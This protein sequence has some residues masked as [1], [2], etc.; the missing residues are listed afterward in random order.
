MKELQV[1]RGEN[2]SL[3]LQVGRVH[4]AGYLFVPGDIVAVNPVTNDGIPCG[5]KWLLLQI[6]KSHL[7]RIGFW[8]DEKEVVDDSAS[9]RQFSLLPQSVKVYF[10]SIIKD[11]AIPLVTPVEELN[12]GWDNGNVSYAF[13][14]EYCAKLG[15]LSDAFRR[16]L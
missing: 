9:G 8:L 12:S 16:N 5:D 1:Q 13:T 4:S 15:T 6:N 2:G 3:P 7:S 11:N 14:A 10:R